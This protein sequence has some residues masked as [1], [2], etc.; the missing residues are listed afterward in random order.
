MV[1]DW[2]A[3]GADWVMS[4]VPLLAPQKSPKAAEMLDSRGT[5]GGASIRHYSRC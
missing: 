5:R 4:R 1:M 3:D 2:K